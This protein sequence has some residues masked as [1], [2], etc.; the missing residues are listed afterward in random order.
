VKWTLLQRSPPC[1]L[2]PRTTA[3]KESTR[4]DRSAHPRRGPAGYVPPL[5]AIGDTG[6]QRLTRSKANKYDIWPGLSDDSA[7]RIQSAPATRSTVE[8]QQEVLDD[9]RGEEENNLLE[10]EFDSHDSHAEEHSVKEEQSGEASLEEENPDEAK[11]RE[12]PPI[13]SMTSLLRC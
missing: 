1:S 7:P 10:K 9:Q 4:E 12:S 8:T 2:S 5:D 3:R 13:E 6:D 11:F